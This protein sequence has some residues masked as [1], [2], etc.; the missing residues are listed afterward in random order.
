VGVIASSILAARRLL[1][2]AT[3]CSGFVLG[4]LAWGLEG[5]GLGFLSSMFP[6]PQLALGTAIGIYAIAVLAG[7][8]SL[9]PGGL[10]STETVMVALLAAQGFALT[11]AVIVTLACRLVTLWLAVGLGWIAVWGLRHRQRALVPSWR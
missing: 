1:R 4:L 11:E 5:V 7:A 8:V 2:P 6:G 10:G 9:L 3:L